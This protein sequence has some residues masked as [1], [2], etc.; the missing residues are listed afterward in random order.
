MRPKAALLDV[1]DN[2]CRWR[3]IPYCSPSIQAFRSAS[4][5]LAFSLSPESHLPP[6]ACSARLSPL[7]PMPLPPD[8]QKGITVRPSKS[9]AS[10]KVLRMRGASADLEM[11]FRFLFT[12]AYSHSDA[13]PA[14]ALPDAPA[15]SRF[16]FAT[17]AFGARTCM[18]FPESPMELPPDVA[19]G[20]TVFPLKS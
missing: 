16:P 9:W 18:F 6:L 5:A 15:A 4:D 13:Q 3:L 17:F 14:R 10:T 1:V 20:T 19:K 7:F 2:V 8:V 11:T 12:A